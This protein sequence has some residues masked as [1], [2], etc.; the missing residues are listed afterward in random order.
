M[1]GY[2]KCHVLLYKLSNNINMERKK[3]TLVINIIKNT[4]KKK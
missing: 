1:N 2:V 3:C 4:N